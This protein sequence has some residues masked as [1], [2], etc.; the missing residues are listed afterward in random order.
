MNIGLLTH[1]Y[2]PEIG[3]APNRLLEM[4]KGLKRE[5]NNVSVL[6]AMPN[7][8]TGKIFSDYKGKFSCKETID[9]VEVKRLWLYASNSKKSIPRIMSM[10][11]FSV[12]SLFGLRYLR[13]KNLDFLI[14]QSPPLPLAW[15]GRWLAKL[16]GAKFVLNVS[17]LWPLSAK[18]M[19]AIS[20]GRLYRAIEKLESYAYRKSDIALGQSQQI[21]DY[22]SERGCRNVHLFRNG[23]DPEIFKVHHDNKVT[24]SPD[25]PLKIIYAG[26]LGYA[27]GI[28][29]ICENI[30]FAALGAEFHIYGQGGEKGK[31]E[32]Y[33]KDHPDKGI[34]YHGVVSR[35]KLP[36]LMVEA[37][38]SI[39]PLVTNI[40]GA[41]PSKI[42][43]SMA[44][45]LPILF[46]GEGE[47]AKIIE[48]NKLGFVFKPK[49]YASVKE[50]IAMIKKNPEILREITDNCLDAAANKF[51]RANQIRLLHQK[52]KKELL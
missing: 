46:M 21:V 36:A 3:A 42:Y 40:Y 27:Q 32:R 19:G 49:D 20:E 35:D 37:D 7:Y 31:L 13:K 1:S 8:P 29:E 26:L 47:G 24:P 48:D 33:I 50:K 15:S 23:V 12:T 44:A 9:G 18:E 30:D 34:F 2:S 38:I 16:S 5:G 43:E 10:A 6:T 25:A 22:I 39:I 45:G 41:V 11:S 52:L 28:A 17:D 4:V 14:V 51:N